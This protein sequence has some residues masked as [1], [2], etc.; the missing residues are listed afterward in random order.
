MT[1]ILVGKNI[2]YKIKVGDRTY[3]TLDILWNFAAHTVSQ[4]EFVLKDVWLAKGMQMEHENRHELLDDIQ[5]KLGEP[6]MKEVERHLFTP[7][8]HCVV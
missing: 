4:N 7:V 6:E 5:A 1:P 3:R 8:N 2:Q